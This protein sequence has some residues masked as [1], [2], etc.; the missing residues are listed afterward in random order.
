[1]KSIK[2][3]MIA[4]MLVVMLAFTGCATQKTGVVINS[5]G[6]AKMTTEIKMDKKA[7]I[8][9]YVEMSKTMGQEIKADEAEVMLNVTMKQMSGEDDLDIKTITEDGKEYYYIKE[10]RNI[11]K[12]KLQSEFAAEGCQSYVTTDTFYLKGEM[13]GSMDISVEEMLAAYKEMGVEMKEEDVSMSMTVQFPNDI[14][15]T[16]GTKDSTNAKVV[17]FNIPLSGK[18][19]MFATTKADVT[20]SNVKATI[21]KLNTVKTTKIKKLKANKI[22][23]NAKKATVTLKFRKVS[24]AK[25]YEIQY[26]TKKNFKKVETKKTKKTTYTIGKLKKGKKYYVRV[27]V[28]KKNYAGM[29]IYSKWVKKSVTTKK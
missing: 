19:D 28:I 9:G 11:K 25:K 4:L 5:D 26:G 21:K 18:V 16:N 22:K 23:K 15:S 13:Y 8:D 20:A 14:V 24:G 27:R 2:T 17:T 6:S 1:M 10:T 3:K 12:S 29:D 7:M